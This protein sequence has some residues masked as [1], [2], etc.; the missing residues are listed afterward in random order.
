LTEGVRGEKKL[1]RGIGGHT[2]QMNEAE[3]LLVTRGSLY[4]KVAAE[5]G[6][7]NER[8]DQRP[9][10]SSKEKEMRGIAEGDSI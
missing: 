2:G 3:T 4:R 9:A 1:A 10:L 7:L 5:V 8:Q 6:A